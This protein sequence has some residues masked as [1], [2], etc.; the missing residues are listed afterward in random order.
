MEIMEFRQAMIEC[1]IKGYDAQGFHFIDGCAQTLSALGGDDMGIVY[2]ATM[3][4]SIFGMDALASAQAFI[5]SLLVVALLIG[6][7]GALMAFRETAQRIFVTLGFGL[8]ALVAFATHAGVYAVSSALAIMT[9]PW[10]VALHQS[11]STHRNQY[12]F[13]GLFLVGFLLAFADFVRA[14]AG[15]PVLFFVVTLLLSS[16]WPRHRTRVIAVIFLIIG[17]AGPITYFESLFQDRDAFL[18]QQNPEYTPPLKR[19]LF[20]HTAYI[21]LG[22]TTNDF[23]VVWSDS[24][25]FKALEARAPGTPQLSVESELVHK[26]LFFETVIEHPV[27]AIM[28]VAAKAGVLGFMI[29]LFANVGLLVRTGRGLDPPLRGAFLAAAVISS[30]YGFLAI[31]SINYTTQLVAIAALYGIFSVAAAIPHGIRSSLWIPL[32]RQNRTD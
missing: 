2:F 6:L 24:H 17:T 27:F 28:N 26:Q 20:W 31:P 22:Y 32:G 12:L 14:Y 1:A 16:K 15:L 11:I 7:M 30:S 3:I 18:I 23:G 10:L 25:A 5:F 19:H 4:H 29:V 8:L 21:G 13:A 9:I